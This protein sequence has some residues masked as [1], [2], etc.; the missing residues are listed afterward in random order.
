MESLCF[1]DGNIA[2]FIDTRTLHV[3]SVRKFFIFP[4]FFSLYKFASQ[5]LFVIL[6]RV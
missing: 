2:D 4:L 5:F 3:R 1:H 6:M